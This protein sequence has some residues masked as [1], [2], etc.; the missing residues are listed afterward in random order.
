MSFDIDKVRADFEI[1]NVGER[2]GDKPLIYLD[3]AA[4]TLKPKCVVDAVAAHYRHEASNIRRGVHSL[5]EAATLKVEQA[6]KSVSDF[7]GSGNPLEVV[8]TSGTTEAL[9][10]AA[11]CLD[12]ALN[13]KV[14]D[15]II[16][17]H[18]EHHSNIL[19]WLELCRQ[20]GLTLKVIPID[21]N[22]ELVM[23]EYYKL[24]SPRTKIVAITLVSNAIGTIVPA[25]E[26]IEAAHGYGAIAVVDAAQAAAHLKIDVKELDCDLLALS[27]HK[28]FGPT[29]IGVLFGKLELLERFRP[30]RVGGGMITQVSFADYQIA[31]L[32]EKFEAGTPHIAGIIGLKAAIDYINNL[33]IE[34]IKAHENL[35]SKRAYKALLEANFI[36]IIG[37][38]AQRSSIFSFTIK[39][40]HPHDIAT[41][42]DEDNIAVRGGHHCAQPLWDFFKVQATTRIS[43][44]I[45]NKKEDI[46]I[47]I[48]SLE[49]VWRLFQ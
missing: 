46:P 20:R 9:N 25:K 30:Y 23:E 10:M 26:I 27:G 17:S 16:I 22:G 40:I 28:L 37:P 48:N 49:R 13:L 38:P 21:Q 35:L 39:G 34:A 4:T 19:P 36:D 6:R 41:L 24:V 45:Y 47:L 32:P 29:G 18:L 15:E 12:H 3:S 43:F 11:Y 42:L 33:T 7:I 44:S 1:L 2:Q 14:G 8:F 31:P 5:S